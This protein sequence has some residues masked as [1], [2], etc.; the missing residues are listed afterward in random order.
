MFDL[1]YVFHAF[2]SL[3]LLPQASFAQPASIYLRTYDTW[4]VT[5]IPATVIAIM[6]LQSRIKQASARQSR[7]KKSSDPSQP[8]LKCLPGING[9][10]ELSLLYRFP[11]LL[12]ARSFVH[13]AVQ[14]GSEANLTGDTAT[15]AWE[16]SCL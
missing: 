1:L 4:T 8:A 5:R 12:S 3:F 11:A 7:G 6:R 2:P 10:G 13:R 16:V 9:A 15:L 14:Y